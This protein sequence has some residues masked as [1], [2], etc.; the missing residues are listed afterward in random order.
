MGSILDAGR[1]LRK[2]LK[3][4]NGGMPMP[5]TVIRRAL[6][7]A[8]IAL[9][10]MGAAQPASA[11]S[12][13]SYPIKPIRLIVG[14]A[15]GGGNSLCDRLVGQKISEYIGQNVVIENKPGAGGRLAGE[16]V[17]NQPA[18]G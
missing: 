7:I 9:A 8:A 18:G 12:Q 3:A 15:A 16:V 5:S 10:A 2:R 11:Q 1:H 14:F 17:K 13:A 4:T 6:C